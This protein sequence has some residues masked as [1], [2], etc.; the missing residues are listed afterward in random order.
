MRQ[1]IIIFSIF[2]MRKLRPRMDNLPKISHLGNGKPK[3]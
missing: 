3:I 1:E 2:K